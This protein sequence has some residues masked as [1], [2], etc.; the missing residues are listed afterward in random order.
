[1]NKKL[2]NLVSMIHTRFPLL[3]VRTDQCDMVRVISKR[4]LVGILEQQGE[5]EARFTSLE[6]ETDFESTLLKTI[7]SSSLHDFEERVLGALAELVPRR[8]KR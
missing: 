2:V 6:G 1:M 4:V 5:F 7:S 3:D 8:T